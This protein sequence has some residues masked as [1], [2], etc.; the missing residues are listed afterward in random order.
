MDEKHNGIEPYG[1]LRE[2]SELSLI[3]GR[4]LRPVVVV[5]EGSGKIGD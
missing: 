2:C 4:S 5:V 3:L 1:L